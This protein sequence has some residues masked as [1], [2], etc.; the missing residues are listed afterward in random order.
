MPIEPREELQNL[1]DYVPGKSIDE[2]CE[3][4]GLSRAVKLASNENPW[5]TSPKAREAF[6]KMAASLHLYPRGNAPALVQA[7]AK[8]YGVDTANLIIGNG[9]D[10][11]IDLIG[12][13]FIRKG[14]VCVGVVPTFS[15]YEFVTLSSGGDFRKFDA[16][17]GKADLRALAETLDASVR[18]VFLC[19]PNNPT[20]AYYGEAEIVEFLRLLPAGTLLFLDEAYAEFATAEDYPQLA[21]RLA[22][23]PNLFLN[24]TFSKI[25]GLAGIRLGYGLAHPEVIRHLWK[26]KPPFDVNIAVQAAA[27]A[28]LGDED[29]VRHTWQS[30]AE[31]KRIL[32]AEL[33]ALGFEV[34]PTEANFVCVHV[35][36]EAAGLVKFLESRG[37][38]VRFLKSF[39]L[40]EW[41]RVTVGRPGELAEFLSLVKEWKHA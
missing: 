24:R 34:L 23:F 18:V 30:N 40:P 27:L 38:I 17:A 5:G 13:A 31:G 22:E 16:G 29:F 6:C 3:S 37:M 20:G 7:L 14:D 35:G 19:N 36:P 21:K 11:V 10:E 33:S 9:S 26:V 32:T 8:K 25:Y 39:G 12:K 2:I 41:I 28:A 15:V 1:S 4:Y